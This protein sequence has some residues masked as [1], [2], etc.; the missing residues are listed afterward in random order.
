[1]IVYLTV[2]SFYF[3][4]TVKFFVVV[5]FYCPDVGLFRPNQTVSLRNSWNVRMDFNISVTAHAQRYVT[6]STTFIDSGFLPLPL[7]M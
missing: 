5:W 4:Q 3:C 1:M 2:N 6:V 7:S